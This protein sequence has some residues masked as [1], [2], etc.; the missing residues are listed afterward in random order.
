MTSS[1]NGKV[2]VITG[3][4]R[5][6]G[7]SHALRL[8]REGADI[9]VCD[10]AADIP[11]CPLTL[12]RPEDL[13]ETVK[14]VE[15][16]DRRCLAIQADVR[17]TAQI[18]GVAEAAMAEFGRIDILCAN[19]GILS[20]VNNS[21]E[22]DDAAWDAMIGVN[23]SGVFKSC[24]AVIP[25]MLAGGNG[26]SIIITSSIA[27]LKALPA[28]THYVA[29]KHG[30]VGLMRAFARE[31]A[32]HS[33]RVNTVHPSA[34]DSPMARDESFGAWAA[35]N[36]EQATTMYANLIPVESMEESDISDAVAFLASDQSKFITGCTLN[37]DAG[38][39][40]K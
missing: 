20:L 8:A 23:L 28:I 31:L 30:T 16:L 38:W 27:G 24:R 6:Q 3:G 22:I 29:A 12:A 18:N 4:A 34:V 11:G 15:A 33:I 21:W 17:D 25:H 14:L 37:V 19:A 40:L 9:V 13:E 32:P 1:L 35:A 10:I 7:R 2:A 39:L 36:A 5:G 26:G